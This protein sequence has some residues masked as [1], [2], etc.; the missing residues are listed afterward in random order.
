MKSFVDVQGVIQKQNIKSLETKNWILENY[1][2]KNLKNKNGNG[3][4]N[5]GTHNSYI[6]CE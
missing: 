2:I 6:L 1:Y 4:D 5:F 3:G